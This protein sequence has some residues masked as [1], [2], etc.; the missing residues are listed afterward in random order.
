MFDICRVYSGHGGHNKDSLVDDT[1]SFS[2]LDTMWSYRRA[3][4]QLSG[5]MRTNS[6]TQWSASA[7]R[8]TTKTNPNKKELWWSFAI[9]WCCTVAFCRQSCH[10]LLA[11]VPPWPRLNWR[12]KWLGK[13]RSLLTT[14]IDKGTAS[15]MWRATGETA[16]LLL[17]ITILF[18]VASAFVDPA[19]RQLFPLNKKKK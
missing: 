15:L 7:Q 4:R 1:F 11:A 16:L 19:S 17:A 6:P 14:A 8:K 2:F 13:T 9:M 3:T 10:Y 18:E 12:S 5:V